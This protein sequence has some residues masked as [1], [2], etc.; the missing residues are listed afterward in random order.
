M[1]KFHLFKVLSLLVIVSGLTACSNYIQDIRV[2][3]NEAEST[4]TVEHW[5]QTVDGKSYELDKDATQTLTGMSMS[6]TNV[7]PVD[8]GGFTSKKI[9]Q[10]KILR[11][12]STVVKVYY[13]RNTITYTFKA[14]GGNWDGS[15][16]DVSISGLYGAG[17]KAPL[18][19][20]KQG[21]VFCEWDLRV[22]ETFGV[23]NLNF[24]GLWAP[25]TGTPYTVQHW[26][27]KVTTD[28]Y[29]LDDAETESKVGV[30][31]GQTNATPKEVA[32][33]NNKLIDQETIAPDG[34]T[35]V[36]VYYDRNEIIYTFNSGEG[37]W[38]E[39]TSEKIVTGIYGA[40]VTNKPENPMPDHSSYLFDTWNNNIPD[41]FGFE[42]KTFTA[43]YKYNLYETVTYLPT[44][45]DG[46]AGTSWTY[47]YFGVW[48]QTIKT[49]NVTVNVSK[50]FS[51]GGNTYYLGS[52][53]CY[54]FI[55]Q[56]NYYKLEPIKWRVL[57]TNYNETGN[58]LLFAETILF[59]NRFQN[60]SANKYATSTIREYLNQSF[61]KM[62]FTSVAGS[63]IQQTKVDNSAQSSNPYGQPKYLGNGVNQFST[64]Y[65][66]DKIFLLSQEEAS[67]PSYGF[68]DFTKSDAARIR[69]F[70]DYAR[71]A[72]QIGNNDGWWWLRSPQFNGYNAVRAVTNTGICYNGCKTATQTGGVV[73]ALTIS[74]K[75]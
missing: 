36:K 50:R 4:F 1:K 24:T 66:Y 12:G 2:S 35:V 59:T 45:T 6:K 74:L 58:A 49:D 18:N 33:F 56:G 23:Q 41:T 51:M 37:K 20:K 13:N 27:Q 40:P 42:N 17:V 11:D 72:N 71:V 29:E 63:K 54:Y 7:K 10:Q 64:G 65:T 57:T 46:T 43:Q 25:G 14:A 3:V 47:V 70:T 21:Y 16:K 55:Y 34:S 30:T 73:P 44:G 52:D 68:G 28:G 39:N 62:A 38:D 22:P 69:N 67:N 53:R 48:P 26:F 31:E 60:G 61:F 5:K 32:G 19:P 9:S 75:N 15:T 8:F